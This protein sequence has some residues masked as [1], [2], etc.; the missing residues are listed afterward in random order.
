MNQHENRFDEHSGF[1][2]Y[3][4]ITSSFADYFSSI[5]SQ[6][7]EFSGLR[8][9]FS[10]LSG[11]FLYKI[12]PTPMLLNASYMLMASKFVFLAQISLL[13]SR[14]VYLTTYLTATA[15][16]EYSCTELMWSLLL[17]P[18]SGPISG[19]SHPC[20]WY[21]HIFNS[22]TSNQKVI[23]D[24]SFYNPSQTYLE[25]IDI[26]SISEYISFNSFLSISTTTLLVHTNI[27][28]HR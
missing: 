7:E 2:S 11:L 16:S 20:Q 12:L 23:I 1:F 27:I 6:K 10:S 13:S 15:I 3:L 4:S 18:K 5:W 9:G 25:L 17:S 26:N 8:S 21:K 24:A 14:S 19:L 22:Q 28:S